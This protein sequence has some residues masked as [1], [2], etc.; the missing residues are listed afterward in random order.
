MRAHLLDLI[1]CLP[2][3]GAEHVRDA[4]LLLAYDAQ[5]RAAQQLVVLEQR[6]G[7]RV[8]DGGNAEQRTVAVEGREERLEALARHDGDGLR[9]EEFAGGRLVE[10]PCNALYGYLFHRF[11]EK[12]SFH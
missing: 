8:L 7:N 10:A 4:D 6:A 11:L 1:D 12:K 3:Q 5:V 9:A 2:G